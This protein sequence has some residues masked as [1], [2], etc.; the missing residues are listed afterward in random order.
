LPW[1]AD[2]SDFFPLSALPA[3]N[4][5]HGHLHLHVLCTFSLSCTSHLCRVGLPSVKT[6]SSMYRA[7]TCGGALQEALPLVLARDAHCL[8]EALR[9]TPL[10]GRVRRVGCLRRPCLDL[11]FVAARLA[12]RLRQVPCYYYL[13][14]PALTSWW[15]WI[16]ETMWD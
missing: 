14:D 15:Q 2:D 4:A 7:A 6:V 5:G 10:R 12:M 1:V 11:G 8:A 3:R 13:D 16:G 9:S